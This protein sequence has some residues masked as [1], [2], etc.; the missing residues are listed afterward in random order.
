VAEG[1]PLLELVAGDVTV[2]LP[3]PASGVLAEQFVEEDDP[4]EVGQVLGVIIAGE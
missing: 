2:D 3:A 1:D 4:V